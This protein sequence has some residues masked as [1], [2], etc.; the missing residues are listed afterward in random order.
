MEKSE[1]LGVA[2]GSKKV[3]KTGVKKWKK[4]KKSENYEKK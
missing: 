3:L 2:G 4:V 1:N